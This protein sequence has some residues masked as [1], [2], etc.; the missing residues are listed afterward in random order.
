MLQ[1]N[2][3][4]TG[5]HYTS[6]ENWLKIKDKGL[7]PARITSE[8]VL[9]VSLET[10]GS[11]LFQHS[12]EEQALL[13]VLLMLYAVHKQSWDYVELEV[14]YRETDCLKALRRGNTITLLH[15][16]RCDD[17]VFHD[18]EPVTIVSQII[19]GN[20][21]RLSRSF[22]LRQAIRDTRTTQGDCHANHN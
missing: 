2:K 4:F 20:R 10:E 17:W 1:S 13:G 6:R 19:P 16:G 3:L 5:Y 15:R 18:G 22:N 8:N 11:W 21:I 14:T 12:Q 7:L 9:S